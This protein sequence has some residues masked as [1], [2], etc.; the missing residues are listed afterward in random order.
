[1]NYLIVEPNNEYMA[2]AVTAKAPMAAVVAKAKAVFQN[3]EKDKAAAFLR[4]NLYLLVCNQKKSTDNWPKIFQ[5]FGKDTALIIGILGDVLAR[6][7][8]TELMDWQ[9]LM[10]GFHLPEAEAALNKV[11]DDRVRAMRIEAV[12]VDTIIREKSRLAFGTERKSS[13]Y[14]TLTAVELASQFCSQIIKSL[15]VPYDLF[16]MIDTQ[17]LEKEAGRI[18]LHEGLIT[19]LQL[20]GLPAIGLPG[21]DALVESNKQKWSK[22]SISK[23]LESGTASVT[24]PKGKTPKASTPKAT[25]AKT[26][27]GA[28]PVFVDTRTPNEQAFAGLRN[29]FGA[30][31]KLEKKLLPCVELVDAVEAKRKPGDV[32]KLAKTISDHLLIKNEYV[33]AQNA[34]KELATLRASSQWKL[35]P[36]QSEMINYIMAGQ[37][38]LVNG[39]TS[40]GKTFASMC[41]LGVWLAKKADSKLAY[42]APTFHLALQTYANI[43]LTFPQ[44]VSLI[45]GVANA[46]SSEPTQVWVGTPCELWNYLQ[47]TGETF[48]TAIIDEVHTLSVSL[49]DDRMHQ[50]R[51]EAISNL[52]GLCKDQVIALSATIHADDLKVLQT[53]ISE[54]TG[55]KVIE[56][57]VYTE[58]PVPV[59]SHV[60][61]GT[62]LERHAEV[63]GALPTTP[64]TP[65]STFGLVKYME[66]RD[67]LPGLVF[68]DAEKGSFN[69][70]S[71]YI[72][73]IEKEERAT[74]PVWHKFKLSLNAL[75]QD[76]NAASEE[77]YSSYSS[78]HGN[79]NDDTQRALVPRV[80]EYITK[81]RKLVAHVRATLADAIYAQIDA[82]AKYMATLSD[83][84]QKLSQRVMEGR[85]EKKV[86]ALFPVECRDLLEE[87]LTYHTGSDLGEESPECIAPLPLVCDSVGPYFRIG[88]Q[89]QEI[90][91]LRVMFNPGNNTV[92][93]K[94]RKQMLALSEAERIREAEV[95]PLFDLIARGLEYGVGLIVTTMPFVVQYEMLR[96]LGKKLIKCVFTSTSMSLGINL[97]VRSCVIRS[98]KEMDINVNTF[99]QMAGRCGRRRLDNQAHVVTWNI[100]N[101]RTA[102][103]STLPRIVLP[104]S[105]ADKGTLIADGLSI[106]L[107]IDTTRYTLSGGDALSMALGL[108]GTDISGIDDLKVHDM[109]GD[110]E[111]SDM[112]PL[113]DEDG[114]ETKAVVRP[115][116][117]SKAM[118]DEAALASAITAC[119]T[120]VAK[121]LGMDSKE[122]TGVTERVQRIAQGQITAEM[123]ENAYEWASTM[124]VISSA[125]RELH[126]KYHRCSNSAW[127]SYIRQ[128]AEILHR[129]QFRQ[130][131]L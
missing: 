13:R 95:K 109:M 59:Q 34:T 113:P 77:I 48:N 92:N 28:A 39:P 7:N 9:R 71:E 55:I 40:G 73:W 19:A 80:R 105:G 111:E 119:I 103:L 63:K 128:T 27:T 75:I 36:W 116:Q 58:R 61:T 49:G 123:S 112:L 50:L 88:P 121:A 38:V 18:E 98:L 37:S 5:V 120:P 72:A 82:K 46:I 129:V 93:W 131:K 85:A 114:G 17:R 47:A 91:N 54:R 124:G 56:R 60:W 21:Q 44:S 35:D 83:R 81:R 122:V 104:A 125:L 70:F 45:T 115:K 118:L 43:K 15:G 106:A 16:K 12:D 79:N 117:V 126:T 51:A 67:M 33:T 90:N 1:M 24:S 57:V 68:D 29:T 108:L 53:F 102:N 41:A 100:R 97:P 20:V 52:M 84:Q 8:V 94:L 127:L 4:A 2:L 6:G 62:T 30:A 76:Y 107:E 78:A 11:V 101:A 74:Y 32:S 66:A 130:M 87:L 99:M 23:L 42:V 10:K 25:A 26:K 14:S 65:E 3:T 31:A 110:D 86:G 69:S 96:M 89:V 22:N 64:I